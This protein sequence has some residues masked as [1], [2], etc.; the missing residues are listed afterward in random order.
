MDGVVRPLQQ[1]LSLAKVGIGSLKVETVANEFDVAEEEIKLIGDSLTVLS[2]ANESRL[3]LSEKL[4]S[5]S[6]LVLGVLP[7]VL[8]SLDISLK[9]LG[10][11]GILED[12]LT[13]GDEVCDNVPLG[14]QLGERLLLSLNKLI[15][16]LETRGGDVSGGGEHDS[17]KELNMGLE[18]IT[19]GVALPV[20]VHHNSGLLD[21]GDEVLVALDKGVKLAKLGVLLFLG[22][23]S[24]QDLEDLL[25]PFPDLSPLQ[26]FAEGIEGVSLP[27]ELRGGVDLVGH[28]PGNGLL[29]IL[30]PLGHLEVPHL[31]DLL[32]EGI[33]L[34]PERHLDLLHL[35]C[36]LKS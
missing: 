32:D 15:N 23:L 9:E 24:H 31:V 12:D 25:E 7:S 1:T 20:E 28:D 17:I 16:I 13:L 21:I 34:L 22:A 3:G 27:L 36:V 4:Q 10:L 33:V 29:N 19:I 11:V 2:I 30:H 14:V 8:D 26:I 35:Y 5:L 18:F 6:G